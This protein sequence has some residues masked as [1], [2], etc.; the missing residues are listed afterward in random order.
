MRALAHFTRYSS[1]EFAVRPFLR[2]DPE[3][4]LRQM[5]QWSRSADEHLRRLAS[6]GS[7]PRLPWALALPE[8]K[9][10]PRPLLPILDQLRADP[11]LYVRRSV[12][13]NLNDIAKDNPHVT[14]DWA[15]RWY[16][17]HPHTDWIIKHACRTLLKRAHP[18]A[19][20]LF[21][22]AAAAHVAVPRLQLSAAELRIGDF[23][24]FELQ[25]TGLPRLGRLRVEYGIDY[26]KADGR[27]ARKIF[28]IAEGEFAVQRRSFSK[29]HSLRQMTT[30]RH[31]PG[32]HRLVIIING[33]PVKQRL[34]HLSENT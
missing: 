24:E 9:R 16:G 15:R 11:S 13:N 8:F 29:R 17:S 2:Q 27:W 33:V 23:L 34:F 25:L 22:Y 26:V 7:R 18:E 31:Y 32:R 19:L 21:A 3:R 10:E 5:Q 30:R 14:L 20:A 1:A 6:E 12:A 28:K 4:M